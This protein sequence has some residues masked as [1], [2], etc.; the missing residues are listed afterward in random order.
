MNIETRAD[1]IN[2]VGLYI[3][4][5]NAHAFQRKI[6]G[7][8]I[9]NIDIDIDTID[10]TFEVSISIL[11]ILLCQGIDSSIDDTFKAVFCRYFD[12]D[13]FRTTL[14]KFSRISSLKDKSK[15]PEIES[16]RIMS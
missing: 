15:L 9:S 6:A 16:I 2:L 14:I 13:T 5:A 12:I 1:S 3:F 10:D 7:L 11:T 4:L 8:L